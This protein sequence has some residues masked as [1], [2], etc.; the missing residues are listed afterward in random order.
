MEMK[1]LITE[2]LFEMNQIELE[3]TSY[4]ILAI[5]KITVGRVYFYQQKTEGYVETKKMILLK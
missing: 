3:T 2:Y 5:R 4:K 1:L